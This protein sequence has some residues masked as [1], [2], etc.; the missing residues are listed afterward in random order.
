MAYT[1][2]GVLDY[3]E[4]V[5]CPESA[6]GDEA[7]VEVSITSSRGIPR[8]FYVPV[9]GGETKTELL[10][11]SDLRRLENGIWASSNYSGLARAVTTG[12]EPSQLAVVGNVE[13]DIDAN[14]DEVREQ[15]ERYL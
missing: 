14:R 3:I 1:I 10:E 7:V 11:T 12:L 5:A 4:R 6:I 2:K 15:M 9:D 13:F 8:T